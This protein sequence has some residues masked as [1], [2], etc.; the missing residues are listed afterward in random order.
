MVLQFHEL[1]GGSPSALP[2]LRRLVLLKEAMGIVSDRMAQGSASTLAAT[3]DDKLGVTMQC[4]RA[5]EQVRLATMRRC[6]TRYPRLAEFICPDDAE[7]RSRPGLTRLRAHA[8]ELGRQS[9]GDDLRQYQAAQH[10]MDASQAQAVKDHLHIRLRRFRTGAATGLRAVQLSSGEITTQADRIAAELASH[11]GRVFRDRPVDKLI[12]ANWLHHVLPS[13]EV[14]PPRD[15]SRWRVRRRDIA[16][17]VKHS[18]RSMAGPDRIPYEAW[19]ILGDLGVDV[20]FGAAQAM[21][22]PDFDAAV[23]AAYGV[24]EG[25]PHPFNLGLLVCLPKKPTMVHAELGEVFSAAATRPLSIVDTSNR[26]L[27][28]CIPPSM[29]AVAGGMGARRAAGVPS[30]T[31]DAG[32]HH[33]P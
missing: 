7:A 28:K 31:L 10:T 33:R 14:R 12:L 6:V 30:W 19:R 3:A 17:A 13:A 2:A 18:G 29:G 16:F 25:E 15:P 26:L 1:A 4:I 32:Q 24:P 22:R 8:V 11:W 20:L 9:I 27:A 23:R 5:T 21:E